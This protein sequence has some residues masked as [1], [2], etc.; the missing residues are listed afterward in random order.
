MQ[1]GTFFVALTF[2]LDFLS[3][4]T[5]QVFADFAINKI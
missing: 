1:I 4:S 5:C 2:G 3:L